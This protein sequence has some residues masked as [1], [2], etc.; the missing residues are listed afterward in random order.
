MKHNKIIILLIFAIFLLSI[1]SIC[2]SEID[3]PVSSGDA[4]QIELSENTEI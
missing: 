4:D 3:T 1:T 2:A